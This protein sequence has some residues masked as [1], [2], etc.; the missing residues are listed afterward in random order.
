MEGI[1]NWL[2]PA[3]LAVQQLAYWPGRVLRDGD[4]VGAAQLTAVLIVAVVVTAGL[5]VRRSRPVA[6]ALVV[7]AGLLGGLFLPEDA[8]LL[9]SVAV[10]VALYSVAVRRPVRTAA[11]AGAALIAVEAVRA[12]VLYPSV[13]E[14]GG[15][16]LV[17]CALF[18]T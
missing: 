12:A 10:P 15:E 11:L 17:N 3:L 9:H 5:G 13:A 14:A 7:E 1:R 4:Q 8:T 16:T 6:A 2:L 18:L